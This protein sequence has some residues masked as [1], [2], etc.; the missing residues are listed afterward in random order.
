MISTCISFQCSSNIFCDNDEKNIRLTGKQNPLQLSVN[1]LFSHNLHAWLP[2]ITIIIKR[3]INMLMTLMCMLFTLDSCANNRKSVMLIHQW[4]PSQLAAKLYKLKFKN[5]WCTCIHSVNIT[6][7]CQKNNN[8][9]KQT[10]KQSI[11]ITIN[12]Y[13]ST[14]ILLKIF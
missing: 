8:N 9:N 11:M 14:S 13:H 7:F 3:E 2:S 5:K 12:H 6:N 4:L 10:N 1:F